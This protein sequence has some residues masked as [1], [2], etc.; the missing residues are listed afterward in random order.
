MIGIGKQHTI[1]VALAVVG[2][3][4][5]MAYAVQAH[6]TAPGRDGRVAFRRYLDVERTTSAIFSVNPDGTKAIQLT[7]PSRGVD[8][9]EP[10]WSPSGDQI[11]FERKLSCPAGGPKDGLNNT[12]DLVYTMARN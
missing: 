1:F 9:R 2:L 7:H 10:D 4:C 3:A 5:A 11:A 12:C 8:D 6:A